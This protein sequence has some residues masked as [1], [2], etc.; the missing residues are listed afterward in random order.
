MDAHGLFVTGT[1]TDVGKT[2][3]S[4][5]VL[6]LLRS[7]GKKTLYFKP[8]QCGPA[9]HDGITYPEGD[10]QFIREVFK[11]PNTT[12]SWLLKTPSSPHIAFA[13]EEL[14]FNAKPIHDK[15]LA[16]RKTFDF[17]LLEGAGGIRVP[18]NDKLEMTDLAK[19]SSFPILVAAQPGLGTINHTLLTLEHLKNS[20]LPIAGFTFCES[21]R[22]QV[23][24]EHAQENARAIQSRIGVPYLG[25]VPYYIDGW[26]PEILAKH[27]LRK[28]LASLP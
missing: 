9:K 21:M 10:A 15:L 22:N 18:I 12:T 25:L 6:T 27:P 5:F 1:G 13:K 26:A 17:V 7:L 8:I 24:P 28:Y 4:G 14:Q 23:E 11:H 16:S 2:F 3:V 20:R 19:M